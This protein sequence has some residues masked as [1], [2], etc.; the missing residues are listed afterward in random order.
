MCTAVSMF[1][2]SG[3]LCSGN[4]IH[5]PV[6]E[7]QCKSPRRIVEY[8]LETNLKFLQADKETG[9]LNVLDVLKGLEAITEACR[10]LSRGVSPK[11]RTAVVNICGN[12][13]L[14]SLNISLCWR[15]RRPCHGCPRARYIKKS[16]VLENL[17]RS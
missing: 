9:F 8:L 12:L 5:A 16:N 10:A 17:Y 7:Q 13:R 15:T 1:R 3:E 2:G 11:L 6:K 4:Q 14:M